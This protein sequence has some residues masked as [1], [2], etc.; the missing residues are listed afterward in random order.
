MLHPDD[1]LN[2]TDNNGRSWESGI[3]FIEKKKKKRLCRGVLTAVM[4]VCSAF[5]GGVIGGA[6]VKSSLPTETVFGG[7]YD[8]RQSTTSELIRQAAEVSGPAV[9][10]ILSSNPDDGCSG[11]IFDS[12]G[13]IITSYDEIMDKSNIMVVL[14]N[15][16]KEPIEAKL[17]GADL[18]TGIAVL[19]ID[20]QNLTAAVFENE[21][22]PQVGDM[23]LSIENPTGE[24]YSGALNIG[25]IS[26]VNKEIDI[27]N[28]TY[29]IIETT[30]PDMEENAGGALCSLDGS[31]IGICLEE[32]NAK[33]YALSIDKV[34]EAADA[35][36]KGSNKEK[37][38]LG[39]EYRYLNS[40]IAKAYG[41]VQGAW[42]TKV[43]N[44]SEAEKA[45]LL[46]GDIVTMAGSQVIDDSNTLAKIISN[47]SPGDS[48]SFKVWR[49][50][51]LI[52][53]TARIGKSSI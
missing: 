34:K 50:G 24:E 5:V 6:Y 25:Y 49:N 4:V 39:I 19:K 14:P 15:R 21:V 13:Y 28:E 10:G 22:Q 42:I 31:V 37:P 23:V 44:N 27:D 52:D 47:S 26:S 9:V 8:A 35:I 16:S 29:S 30:S 41:K 36:V 40:E 38:Y 32:G 51:N 7:Q 12:A 53:I 33:G 11:I 17:V 48:I 45:G 1:G 43:R 20:I 46:K 18:K 2:K 3:K